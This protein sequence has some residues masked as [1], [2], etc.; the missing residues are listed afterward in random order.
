MSIERAKK[1]IQGAG[2]RENDRK[3]FPQWLARYAAWA[4]ISA[5]Q[6]LPVNRDV[7][8]GFL[9]SIKAQGKPTWQRLQVMR[10]VE[11]YAA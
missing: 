1:A 10:A 4:K 11:F 6:D 2:L 5:H 9:R 7:L 3:W 8:I